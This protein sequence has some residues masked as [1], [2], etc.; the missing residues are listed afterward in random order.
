MSLL[1]ALV[2]YRRWRSKFGSCWSVVGRF[3]IKAHALVRDIFDPTFFHMPFGR[4]FLGRKLISFTKIP[5]TF[6]RGGESQNEC[7]L[8]H[9]T[10]HT[11]KIVWQRLSKTWKN[12]FLEESS[13]LSFSGIVINTLS[14]FLILVVVLNAYIFLDRLFLYESYFF[15]LIRVSLICVAFSF[16]W[17]PS[18]WDCYKWLIDSFKMWNHWL[19]VSA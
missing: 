2:G 13:S 14:I 3:L 6:Q 12:F 9:S 18:S 7:R 19:E 11:H 5:L 4:K 17:R 1:V 16:L 8:T 10:P 15:Y